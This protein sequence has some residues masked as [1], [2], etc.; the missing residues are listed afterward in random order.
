[1]SELIPIRTP[2]HSAGLAVLLASSIWLSLL[3]PPAGAAPGA[4]VG[5]AIVVFTVGLFATSLLPAHVAGLLFFAAALATGI[6]PPL[7]VLSGFWS[8][9]A[10]LVLGGLVIGGAA[11]RT[12]LGRWVAYRV[13]GPFMNSYAS[14]IA[15]I[16][17]GTG[18]LSFLVPSTMGRLAIT[19]PIVL[20][21]TQA[22]GYAPGSRGHVGCIVTTVAGN[23]LT[24][25]GILPS[26]LANVIA[27]GVFEAQGGPAF[28]YGS[29]LLMCYP[30]L[31]LLKAVSFWATVVL[32]CPA[33]PPQRTSADAPPAM[34]AP[35]KRLAL[36]IAATV[37]VWA[38]DF[39]HH[40]KP[41]WVALGAALICALPPVSV[42]RIEESL[43]PDKLMGVFS[44]AAVLG[45][46]TVLSYSGAGAMVARWLMMF[47]EP[48]GASAA[49]GFVVIALATTAVSMLATV[50]GAIAVIAPVLFTIAD[51]TGLPLD[52]AL[53]AMMTGLQTVP[54]PFQAV[55]I[56]VGLAM[57]KVALNRAMP[58]M[59]GVA[60]TGLLVVLPA[61]VA[62]M[63][64][65]GKLAR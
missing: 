8:N 5:L 54:L 24:S 34:T 51:S 50:V 47:A 33:P 1:M 10:A 48:A 14:L 30:G 63:S 16:L 27:L 37:A 4:M 32:V 18:I 13:L 29:Y 56:M 55:P 65:L 20:A 49:Y 43:D 59:L 31:G 61:N 58:I 23:Y 21:A 15:G 26:N 52:A 62:W 3:P 45:V 53:V 44:L 25:Y 2:W 40:V 36:V 17:I 60:M 9:A 19:I 42:A 6:A 12:G 22:A 46:A 28:R 41:G 64:A 39:V 35:A 7:V 38:L 57:G 11:A